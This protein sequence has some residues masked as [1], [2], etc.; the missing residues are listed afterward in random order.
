MSDATTANGTS[1]GIGDPG[2][3]A[4]DLDLPPG[5]RPQ[6]GD[7]LEVS[8]VRHRA[9]QADVQL[10]EEVRAHHDVVR[11]GQVRDLQ[12][13]RDATDPGHVDLDDAGGAAPEVLGEL[14]DRVHRLASSDTR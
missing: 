10:H 11:F 1:S 14:A 4:V 2:R 3:A 9:A 12:P 6:L 13:R 5:D 8:A 7:A